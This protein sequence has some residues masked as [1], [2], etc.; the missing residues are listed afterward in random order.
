MKISENSPHAQPLSTRGGVDA[1][2]NGLAETKE[3]VGG[4]G[5]VSFPLPGDDG[6]ESTADFRHRIEA[7]GLT[8]RE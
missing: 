7:Y 5:G 2:A 4:G 1:V 3:L 6:Y 8:L